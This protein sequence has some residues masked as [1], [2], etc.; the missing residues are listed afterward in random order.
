MFSLFS[1]FRTRSAPTRRLTS[2]FRPQ[3]DHLERRECPAASLVSLNANVLAGH[4]VQLS[5]YVQGPTAAG[6]AVEIHGAAELTTIADA[7]GY[8][9]VTTNNANLG[10]V[11]ATAIDAGSIN[12]GTATAVIASPKPTVTMSATYNGDTSVTLN[13]YVASIDGIYTTVALSGAIGT[14]ATINPDA[15]GYFTHT[16]NA[17]SLGEITATATD[18][19]AESS[20]PANVFLVSDVPAIVNFQANNGFFN[21]I[22][23][24]GQV[25]DENPANRVVTFAG[26]AGL[27][28]LTTTTDSNG[29]FTLTF[30]RAAG[31]GGTVSATVTDPWGQASTPAYTTVLASVS[32]SVSMSAEVQAGHMVRLTG[33]VVG[34][35]VA[36]A[37]V[38]M[39]GAIE[40]STLT[41]AYGYFEVLSPDASL[42]TVTVTVTNT[43][44]VTGDS[45]SAVIASPKPTV[46][47]SATYNGDTS[48]T[49]NGYVASIDGIYTTVSLSGAIGTTATINPDASG[50]FTHTFNAASLGEITATATD[51]WAESSDPASVFLVSDVPAIVE[52]TANNGFFDIVTVSGRVTDENPGGRTVT[53]AG[54][55]GLTGRTAVTD[56]NGNFSIT[57]TRP[58]G[59]SATI[60][61]QVLDPWGQP[62]APAYTTVQ[63]GGGFTNVTV[64]SQVLAGYQVML[65]GTLEGYTVAGSVVTFSGAVTGSTIADA[66]G[67]YSYIGSISSL[68]DVTVSATNA[69][70]EISSNVTETV[71]K[72][73][74]TI[75]MF[76]TYNGETSVTLSGEVTS[77]DLANT[78]VTITSPS[79]PAGTM[80]VYANANGQWSITFDSPGLYSYYATATDAWGT[81]SLPAVDTLWTYRPEIL[82]LHA[83]VAAND[84][85]TLT[86]RIFDECPA[87]R[88][89][90]F[91]GISGLEFLDGLTTTTDA[92][93]D[94]TLTFT[95]PAGVIG[96]VSAQTIDPWGWE[97]PR[98]WVYL[99][100]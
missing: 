97:S 15:S 75:T 23:L 19:W 90:T 54:I 41:D 66:N 60:S 40:G 35:G 7:N 86:G 98:Y 25:T 49:L 44:D 100:A 13:G 10:S 88:L 76:V 78:L 29:Y 93:G 26:M 32:P 62:S 20:D 36:G 63:A 73:D 48:V 9:A 4:T 87:G 89:V 24:T 58:P 14:T 99:G 38:T 57:F 12:L 45:V 31:A 5:G 1:L 71:T 17:A 80:T 67:N 51:T 21:I 65:T 59:A 22:T 33:Y 55:A 8:F 18:T 72:P 68:G 77:V 61:A 94:F 39:Q 91:G 27:T 79:D 30:T 34:D 43:D 70:N 2:Y 42:G 69:A 64:D 56:S 47:M 85:I 74:P 92:N 84:V 11:S 6:A 96:S 28:G 95:R 50:Y 16:F 53:F 52:F 46:T 3:I 83:N 81:E 37:V 82:E